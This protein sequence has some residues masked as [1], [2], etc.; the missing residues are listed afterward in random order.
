MEN[1]NNIFKYL[2]LP[3]YK[4]TEYLESVDLST[5]HFQICYWTLFVLL[6]CYVGG[7][8]IFPPSTK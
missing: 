2:F 1:E 3:H 5:R 8:A 7:K 6:Y 4:A